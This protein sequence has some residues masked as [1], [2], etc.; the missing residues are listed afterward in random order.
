MDPAQEGERLVAGEVADARAGIEEE[1]RAALEEIGGEV[2]AGGEILAEPD[3]VEPGMLALHLAERRAQELD[4]DVDRDIALRLQ[5]RKQARRLGA[6]A[7][8]EIDQDRA[9]AARG[10]HAGAV[11]G[12]DRRLGARRVVLGELGDRLEQARA[13]GVVEVLRRDRRSRRA[14]CRACRVGAGVGDGVLDEARA[15][16]SWS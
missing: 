2:E 10:A 4:R 14:Q 6:I 1:R 15:I 12:E 5:R 16:W 13:E 7:G 11:R 3:H 8:A 9:R